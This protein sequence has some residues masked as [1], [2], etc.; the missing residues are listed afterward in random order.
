MYE[1]YWR[2]SSAPFA[3][4]LDEQGFYESSI[5]EE[6]LARLYYTVEQSKALAVLHGPVGC[7]KSQLMSVLAGQIRRTQRF[8]VISHLANMM[9][10]DLL[11]DLDNQFRLGGGEGDSM[12]SRWTRLKDFLQITGESGLQSVLL[13][14][15]LEEADDSAV[16]AIRRLIRL[17]YHQEANLTVIAGL[18]QG[19]FSPAIHELLEIADLGIEVRPLDER[20]TESYVRTRLE[21][22][23]SGREVFHPDAIGQLQNLTGGVPREINRLCD[24]ALLAGMSES[25]TA[26]DRD[27]ITGLAGET[28]LPVSS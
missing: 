2:L 19:T 15:G 23:G 25:R 17:T 27:L 26:I 28:R 9:E 8:L 21:S 16:N 20:E 11:A 12:R 18:D 4:R 24:L 14:D 22:A 1:H 6:A 5:H 13:L 7:G 3:N 10:E